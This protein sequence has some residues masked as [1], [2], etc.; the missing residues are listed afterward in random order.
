[1]QPSA[2]SRLVAGLAVAAVLWLFAQLLGGRPHALRSTS[3]PPPS[4][5]EIIRPVASA[6]D[7]CLH[8]Y[9]RLPCHL[10]RPVAPPPGAPPATTQ[11]AQYLVQQVG[12][13]LRAGRRELAILRAQENPADPRGLAG[14]YALEAQ[15]IRTEFIASPRTKLQYPAM[16]VIWSDVQDE[17]ERLATELERLL[18]ALQKREA[19]LGR[20]R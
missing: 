13:H 2:R 8:A 9:E 15:R 19:L 14:W 5:E 6:Y 11:P 1:M 7:R 16:G 10:R 18:P 17:L 12:G 20:S 3:P 4:V